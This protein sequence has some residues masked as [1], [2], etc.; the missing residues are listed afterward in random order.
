[1]TWIIMIADEAKVILRDF[2]QPLY[3]YDLFE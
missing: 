3:F 2:V 1:M